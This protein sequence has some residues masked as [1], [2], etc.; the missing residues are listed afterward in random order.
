MYKSFGLVLVL[1]L[2]LLCSCASIVSDSK[3]P[4]NITSIPEGATFK[5]LNRQGKLITSGKTPT[6]IML[7]SGAGYFKNAK[8]KVIFEK[9]GYTSTTSDIEAYLDSWYIGNII[10]FGSDLFLGF[11]VIDPLTG[12]MWQLDG[13]AY[14][15]LQLK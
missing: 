11:L 3:Y 6:I 10:F 12:A 13:N 15:E 2:I 14:G 4:V 7:K 5:V 9:S 8:Y 1:F